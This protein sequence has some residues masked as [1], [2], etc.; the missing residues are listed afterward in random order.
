MMTKKATLEHVRY[1]AN[2][3]VIAFPAALPSTAAVTS[4]YDPSVT[5]ACKAAAAKGV[6]G[7]VRE[8]I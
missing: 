6:G 5:T 1:I 2:I 7:G 8:M 3:Q 4:W